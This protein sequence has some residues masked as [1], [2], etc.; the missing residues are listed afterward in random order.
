[1][2]KRGIG[3]VAFHEAGYSTIEN[4]N[5]IA[6]YINKQVVNQC[7]VAIALLRVW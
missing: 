7:S 4:G 3:V 1:M 6:K 5:A 2:R